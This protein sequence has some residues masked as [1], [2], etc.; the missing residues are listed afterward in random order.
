LKRNA[1]GLL[2]LCAALSCRKA[3]LPA[4]EPA[5]PAPGPARTAPI[6]EEPVV[7]F[8]VDNLL[9][10]A[11]GASVVSR[12]GELGLE[13]SA[14]HAVDGVDRSYWNSTPGGPSQTLVFSLFAP[15]RINR[16][17]ILPTRGADQTPA[18]VL[19]D[20]S[21]DGHH[22]R[23][24]LAFQP[25]PSSTPVLSDVAPFTARYLRVRIEEPHNYYAFLRSIYA[26]GSELKPEPRP[27]L[28]GCWQINGLPARIVQEGARVAGVI[29]TDP[30][31]Q[32]EGGTDGRV[33][34]LYWTRGPMWGHAILTMTPE[35]R[36]LTILPFHE[37]F[38]ARHLGEAYFGE[39]CDSG[40]NPSSRAPG[41]P[42]A[43]LVRRTRRFTLYGL[44]F[45]RSE[46][47]F[48]EPSNVTLDAAA[49]LI[50]STASQR[51][52]VVAH[53]LRAPS[54]EQNQASSAA[55]IEAVRAALQKRGVDLSRVGFV[56]AGSSWS[57]PP[58]DYAIQKLLASRIDLEQAP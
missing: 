34:R 24:V 52:R 9:N 44:A 19:F 31:T 10:L 7:D 55:R 56:A 33:A 42:P 3:P 49:A 29:D 21:S 46:H 35:G 39:R 1:L 15:S 11:Y 50:R 57:G 48:E 6:K 47:L 8:D 17:G 53:E 30:P 27:S 36:H 43:E 12:T 41:I 58:V 13:T 23:E 18:R 4:A 37:E 38:D 51:Y 25:R 2:L 32:L 54:A 20:A 14:A 5:R 16:L 22:W 40:K 26:I 45:D 28:E